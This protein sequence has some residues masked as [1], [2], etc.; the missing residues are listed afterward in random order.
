[1]KVVLKQLGSWDPWEVRQCVG[2]WRLRSYLATTVATP[3][4]LAEVLLVCSVAI[5]RLD[6]HKMDKALGEDT[7]F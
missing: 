1:V 3:G 7:K 4:W 6:L 2:E 5:G